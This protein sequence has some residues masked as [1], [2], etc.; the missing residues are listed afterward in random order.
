[1]PKI[2]VMG[3]PALSVLRS[4]T[5]SFSEDMKSSSWTPYPWG[6]CPIWNPKAAF[7][8]IDIRSPKIR[9]IFAAEKPDYVSHHPAQM[10][11]RRSVVEPLFDYVQ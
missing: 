7:Y 11:V 9:E 2:L 1:M 5:C 6:D 8:Q 10:D 4:W 3:K